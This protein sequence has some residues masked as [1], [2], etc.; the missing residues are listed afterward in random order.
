MSSQHN[1]QLGRKG[2][3]A[4]PEGQGQGLPR[5]ED[6]QSFA[7]ENPTPRPKLSINTEVAQAIPIMTGVVR[8]IEVLA[9]KPWRPKLPKFMPLYNAKVDED[10]FEPSEKSQI[11]LTKMSN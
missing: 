10:Q 4:A 9:P 11:H 3:T 2:G 7:P 1:T 6:G 5:T 8:A